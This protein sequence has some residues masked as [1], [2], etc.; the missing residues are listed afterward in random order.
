VIK[1]LQKNDGLQNVQHSVVL[2]KALDV[3]VQHAVVE[4]KT[5]EVTTDA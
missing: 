3:L 1:S 5:A 2:A 4:Y